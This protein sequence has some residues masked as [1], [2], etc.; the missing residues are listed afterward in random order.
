MEAEAL[1]YFPDSQSVQNV[2]F[3]SEI[4]PAGHGIHEVF[5]ELLC[6]PGLHDWHSDALGS[7]PAGHNC[8]AR[9]AVMAH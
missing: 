2:E 9:E 8:C 5:E 7:H 1:L 6:F 3:L 4:V